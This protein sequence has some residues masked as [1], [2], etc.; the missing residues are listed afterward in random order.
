MMQSLH[1]IKAI[2]SGQIRPPSRLAQG[3]EREENLDNAASHKCW[4]P[5]THIL[6]PYRAAEVWC[7]PRRGR[8][9]KKPLVAVFVGTPVAGEARQKRL[10]RQNVGGS[11]QGPPWSRDGGRWVGRTALRREGRLLC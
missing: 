5:S 6:S 11:A 9:P 8:H 2:T 1:M 3:G 7:Q 10:A 4:H